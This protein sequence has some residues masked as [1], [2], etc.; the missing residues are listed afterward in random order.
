M[1]KRTIYV[2]SVIPADWILINT[3]DSTTSTS[4][5]LLIITVQNL[6]Y[7][8]INL[9]QLDCTC[10]L[11][12][13][14]H[15]VLVRGVCTTCT[16]CLWACTVLHAGVLW[17]NQTL[18]SWHYYTPDPSWKWKWKDNAYQT[19]G[20]TLTCGKVATLL[21]LEFQ[22]TSEAHMC[23]STKAWK[24]TS[25]NLFVRWW[26]WNDKKNMLLITLNLILSLHMFLPPM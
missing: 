11:V 15:H 4:S 12:G 9:Q 24:T 5:C 3:L 2:G 8:C 6:A 23:S 10:W 17:Q 26:W 13:C 1:V 22:Q 14:T 20:G 18:S 7:T 16:V 25:G 21:F 19:T